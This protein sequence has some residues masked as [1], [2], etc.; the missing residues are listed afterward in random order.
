VPRWKRL[1][2]ALIQFSLIKHEGNRTKAALYVGYA[3]RTLRNKINES[4]L[5][6]EE[7][8][9]IDEPKKVLKAEAEY[10][11]ITSKPSDG[12]I[13]NIVEEMYKSSQVYHLRGLFNLRRVMFKYP[14]V[15]EAAFN[16]LTKFDGY[17]DSL[18]RDSA[19]DLRD[20]IEIFIE[21][22]CKVKE[23]V[24]RRKIKKI[25]EIDDVDEKKINE[26]IAPI[27]PK[28][29]PSDYMVFF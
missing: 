29:N 21:N 25:K 13:K 26:I 11:E 12:S 9:K 17:Y 8:A 19:E 2:E 15:Q 18:T 24:V 7:L 1:E 27:S 23:N 6:Q 14:Q 20:D 22:G 28:K 10:E 16:L 4:S 5:L 3:Q